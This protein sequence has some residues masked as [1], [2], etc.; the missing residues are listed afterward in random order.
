MSAKNFEVGVTLFSTRP[1]VGP[2]KLHPLT[3]GRMLVLEERGNPIVLGAKPGDE[4]SSWV[5]YEVLMSA[6]MEEEDFVELSLA[7]DMEWK[8]SVRLFGIRVKD[9]DLKL[10]WAVLEA[11]IEA[12]RKAQTKAKK[13]TAQK[14][15]VKTGG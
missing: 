9:E 3:S 14:K 1:K 2:W 15:R 10:F 4:V 11:E 12:I 7:D 8:R 5:V 13:K 6:T